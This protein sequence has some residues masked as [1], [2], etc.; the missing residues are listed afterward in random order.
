MMLV[1]AVLS[2][3]Q[4]RIKTDPSCE[5]KAKRNDIAYAFMHGEKR[6]GR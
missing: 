1:H 6:I 2:N 5:E 4:E 3:P